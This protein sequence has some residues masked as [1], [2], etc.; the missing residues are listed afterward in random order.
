M[1]TP[2]DP[3]LVAAALSKALAVE[4]R[5]NALVP[6]VGPVTPT[7]VYGQNFITVTQTGNGDYTWTCPAGVTSAKVE[8]WGAGGGG[9]GG[10]NQSGAGSTGGP[11]GGGG[12]YAQEPQLAVTPGTVYN[13]TIGNGGNG[14]VTGQG[15][16][17]GGDTF[18]YGDNTTVYANGGDASEGYFLAGNGGS[19]SVNT[20]HY[21]GGHGGANPGNTGAGGGG[22]SAGSTGPGGNG[23]DQSGASGGAGGSA[24][25]G[26]GAIGGAGGANTANGTNGGTPGGGGGGG[27]Y[28]ANAT[29]KTNSYPATGSRAYYGSDASGYGGT[30]NAVRSTNSTIY[31]GGETA[32]G[33]GINGTQKSIVTFNQSQIASDFSGFT[34]TSCKVWLTNQHSWYNSGQ[35]VYIGGWRA[36]GGAPGSWDGASNVTHITTQTI[37]EG[38]RASFGLSAYGANFAGQASPTMYGITLGPGPAF[39]LNYYGYFYG[40]N[41]GGNAPV[42]TISGQ[43]GAGSTTAG[44]GQDG[45]VK[46]TY[47][48]ASTLIASVQPAGVTD[49]SGN[50]MSTGYMGPGQAIQPGSS[51]AVPETWHPLVPDV[52]WSVVSGY[53]DMKYRMTVDGNLQLAGIRQHAWASSQ[54]INS[55]NPLPAAY[56]PP[57]SRDFR[58]SDAV[59]SRCHVRLDPN[60]VLTANGV[61]GGSGNMFA[62]I[63]AT[64]GLNI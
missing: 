62:E 30:N 57:N 21:S 36:S 5:L 63:D 56:R 20:I 14:G 31:Q 6:Q 44:A 61:T 25:T 52:G 64:I 22:G 37:G 29:N 28:G 45:Q 1:S 35:S 23:A 19:G 4:A 42:L 38:S 34:V 11:G 10:G 15:G 43:S 50:T 16:V 49:S 53:A 7:V 48:G 9:N 27:G 47:L 24:G 46:I 40:S 32:S 41:G 39:N 59:G 8:C 55:S 12:E 51:P 18:F 58:T 13:Y 33:G 26:G 60:G 3:S 2:N 17:N 54:A